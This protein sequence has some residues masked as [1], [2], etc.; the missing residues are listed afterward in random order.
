MTL[1]YQIVDAAGGTDCNTGLDVST[2][3]IV[4]EEPVDVSADGALAA[5]ATR[6]DRGGG[7]AMFLMNMLAN[8]PVPKTVIDERAAVC[9]FSED[10]LR[11]AKTKMGVETFKEK[12]DGPWFWSLPQ[13]RPQHTEA[14]E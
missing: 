8:G 10:Q 7:A 2:S 1:A 14:K 3:R 5:T 12:F 11:G 9:G 13:H 4:W 6:K